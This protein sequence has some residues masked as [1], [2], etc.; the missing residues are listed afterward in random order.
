MPGQ[1]LIS[2]CRG[3]GERGMDQQDE[4][5]LQRRKAI[6][7]L[8]FLAAA[9]RQ[10][11]FVLK[12]KRNVRAERDRNLIKLKEGQHLTEQFIQTEQRVG[13]V[14]AAAT[15]AGR[16]R[17]SLLQMDACSVADLRGLQEGFRGAVDQVPRVGR[18]RRFTAGHL[19][20]STAS[21]EVKFV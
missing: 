10:G 21:F 1:S 17:N 6:K 15:Q 14:A 5:A 11:R 12:K 19:N 20:V 8:D 9:G 16:Q 2:P 3:N 18:Q 13:R 7:G 4:N